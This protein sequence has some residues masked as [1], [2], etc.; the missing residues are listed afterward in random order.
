MYESSGNGKKC[1]N[2]YEK[3]KKI[4]EYG[5]NEQR[6]VRGIYMYG[7]GVRKI[8]LARG[9]LHTCAASWTRWR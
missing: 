1:D 8:D 4:G 6:A 9:K 7:C 2:W 3:G 5:E